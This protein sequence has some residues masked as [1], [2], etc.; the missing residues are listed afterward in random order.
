MFS[1]LFSDYRPPEGLFDEAFAAAREPRPHWQALVAQLRA[2]GRDALR[3]QAE[4]LARAV[5]LD[6]VTYN[7]YA[8][9][10]GADRPWS[11]DPLPFVIAA[12]EW[13]TIAAGV[14]QRARLL[15]RLLADVYG[16]R[17]LL[18]EGL[19][20]P[21]L[22]FGHPGYLWPCQ[23]LKPP[24]D[25]W[26]HLYAVDLARSSDGRWWVIHDRTQGPSG[27]G[28]AMQNRILVTRGL[29][30]LFR[31]QRI[32][33][34]AEFFRG[35][36]ETLM[37]SVPTRGEPPMVVLLTPGPLNETYFE[38]SL[39]ARHLGFPLVEG[40]DLTVRDDRVFLK[41]LQGLKPV[42]GIL[43]RLDD[44]YCDPAELR[45]DSALGVPGLLSA[46]RAGN[47]LI[48]NALG[49]GLLE[50]TGLQGF[51]PPICERLL[52][53]RLQLPSVAT[54][55]CGEAPALEHVIDHLEDLVIKPAFP[56]MRMSLRFGHQ[57][58]TSERLNLISRLRATPHAFQAQEWIRLS[59][60]PT[61]MPDGRIAP[62]AV[63]VRVFAIA[64]PEGYRVMPGGLARVAAEA[65]D[66]V[67]TMQ[68][69]GA[70]KDVWIPSK[71]RVSTETL[72]PPPIAVHDLV[73][74]AAVVP[75]RI[76][77]N[78]F[79]LGRYSERCETQ[80]RLLRAAVTRLTESGE[81]GQ[82][83]LASL[84]GVCRFLGVLP[85]PEEGAEDEPVT[86]ADWLAAVF[87]PESPSSLL[88]NARSLQRAGSQVRERLSGDNW[89]ALNRLLA[90]VDRRARGIQDA[91]ESLDRCMM[92]CLS[93]AGFAMDDMTR[94]D[95]WRF[96]LLGRRI[97]RLAGLSA[98]IG[99]F[100]ADPAPLRHAGLE[101]LLEATDS[102]VTYR[103]RYRRR[104]ELL[105][106]LDLIVFDDDNP[107][108]LSFQLEVLT[109][110]L[111]RL[112][113]DYGTRI[114]HAPGELLDRLRRFDPTRFHNLGLLGGSPGG[115]PI[116]ALEALTA[117]GSQLAYALSDELGLTFFSHAERA[118]ERAEAA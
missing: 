7:V 53:E 32:E 20:P 78:L 104:P 67:V 115:D 10:K 6:G 12:D 96:L 95:S 106:V 89:H 47:V 110:Y 27:A 3:A 16:P 90:T 114:S 64:T 11:L 73:R 35:M 42:H 116:E 37:S 51:L 2:G 71:G 48:A 18:A 13:Q 54:W 85:T 60:A 99:R 112:G 46:A 80:A 75:S 72:I 117:E 57:L 40:Q 91:I 8:D 45:A 86:D 38:H 61:L 111:G 59:T 92:L 93:L 88:S 56:T 24:G 17:H 23:G 50:T 19:L 39:L 4:S 109:R 49:T 107:H 79:W 33:H 82:L 98:L 1:A 29:L 69:G 22:I 15:D 113:R 5:Q 43:R 94:D 21:A 41:T 97:E 68:H 87:D 28:Y 26:L 14:A 108:A 63:G 25:R 76:A 70:S 58:G 100:L 36:R 62:R 66:D 9:P 44:D 105:P 55:W 102:I 52:G 34:L 103:A 31:S 30:Q 77:E 81:G 65:G 83:A 84:A 101:W 118:L 74:S